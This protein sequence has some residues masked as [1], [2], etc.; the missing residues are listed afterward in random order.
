AR[1]RR[2][3]RFGS[4]LRTLTKNRSE[5]VLRADGEEAT[6]GAGLMPRLVVVDDVAVREVGVERGL[7]VEQVLNGQVDFPVLVG[8]PASE[9]IERGERRQLAAAIRLSAQR[10]GRAVGRAVAVVDEAGGRVGDRAVTVVLG[11]LAL[12]VDELDRT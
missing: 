7:P 12:V 10:E 4:P 1:A 5:R 11:G 6:D 8:T 3:R 2:H 9:Q